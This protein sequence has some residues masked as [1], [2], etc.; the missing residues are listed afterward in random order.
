MNSERKPM[1]TIEFYSDP[2]LI[3]MIGAVY[4]EKKR[5]Q[6]HAQTMGKTLCRVRHVNT[7]EAVIL[8]ENGDRIDQVVIYR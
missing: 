2:L 1:V 4:V 6:E 3:Q 8:D 5:C 7:V